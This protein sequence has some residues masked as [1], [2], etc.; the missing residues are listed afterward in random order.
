VPADV[1]HAEKVRE[2]AV[3]ATGSGMVRWGWTDIDRFGPIAQRLRSTFRPTPG[4]T[5]GR[6]WPDLR[7]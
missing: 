3:R 4:R 1:L 6:P 2:D 7:P 5:Q